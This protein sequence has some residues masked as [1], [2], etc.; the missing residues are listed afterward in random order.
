MFTRS[1]LQ[2]I[3]PKRPFSQGYDYVHNKNS[4]TQ[5]SLLQKDS[6]RSFHNQMGKEMSTEFFMSVAWYVM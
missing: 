5:Y 1:I 4:I 3:T 6:N 2:G